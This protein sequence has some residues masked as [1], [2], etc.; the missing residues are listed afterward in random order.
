MRMQPAILLP[1][2]GALI[3]AATACTSDP[4]E[5][6][7]EPAV[8]K[9]A[10]APTMEPKTDGPFKDNGSLRAA[11][12]PVLGAPIPREMGTIS[13]SDR[14]AGYEAPYG[15]RK[16]VGFYTE[17]LD[18]SWK[19]N[20]GPGGVKFANESTG[21]AIYVQ[22]PGAPSQLPRVFYFGKTDGVKRPPTGLVQ[23][24]PAPSEGT[25]GGGQGGQDGGGSG[26]KY[27]K[28]VEK[29]NGRDVIVYTPKDDA[30][31]ARNG[32]GR[33]DLSR[34]E[35]GPGF[36]PFAGPRVHSSVPDGVLH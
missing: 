6:A 3:C 7:V 2:L 31:A 29:R 28:S 21:G 15:Y 9:V 36:N 20:R 13:G 16:L 8:N 1:A 12:E 24:T 35:K 11:K 34:H 26:G 23:G 25:A 10:L 19:A 32:R 14:W 27:N 5:P 33:D 18:A 30:D 22:K 4:A 17:E